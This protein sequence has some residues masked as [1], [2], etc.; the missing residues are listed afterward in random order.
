[1]KGTSQDSL[2]LGDCE[3]TISKQLQEK[4]ECAV[5]HLDLNKKSLICPKIT[6]ILSHTVVSQTRQ[7]VVI[8]IKTGTRVLK[9]LS[10]SL[11]L[12]CVIIHGSSAE[13]CVKDPLLAVLHGIQQLWRQVTS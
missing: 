12:H 5:S 11:T 13:D 3:T 8:L 6:D 1:M 4:R 10:F 7:L 2:A 9:T